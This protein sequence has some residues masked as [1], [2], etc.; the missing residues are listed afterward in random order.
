MEISV[1]AVVKQHIDKKSLRKAIGDLALSM[2]VTLPDQP[3]HDTRSQAAVYPLK[4]NDIDRFME[5]YTMGKPEC[6]LFVWVSPD[7]FESTQEAAE[8]IGNIEKERVYAIMIETF[9]KQVKMI[10]IQH[11]QYRTL[12]LENLK[13]LPPVQQ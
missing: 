7:A 4:I 5:L 3:V 1:F 10:C 2:V 11:T 9:I 8:A 12:K 6:K 13:K